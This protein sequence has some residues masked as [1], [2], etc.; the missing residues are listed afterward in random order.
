MWLNA[1]SFYLLVLS[2]LHVN[3][4][5]VISKQDLLRQIKKQ[6]SNNQTF[7]LFNFL[8][9]QRDTIV[10]DY[11]NQ[12]ITPTIA[13]QQLINI[14]DIRL[15]LLNQR[16]VKDIKPLAAMLSKIGTRQA[17]A[18]ALILMEELVTN[19]P[20]PLHFG[21]IGSL[22]E[23]MGNYEKAIQYYRNELVTRAFNSV[24]DENSIINQNNQNNQNN[25]KKKKNIL[26][27]QFIW[28]WLHKMFLL[29]WEHIGLEDLVVGDYYNKLRTNLLNYICEKKV[30]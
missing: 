20:H 6:S 17:S 25:L 8:E 4:I 18:K 21:E 26:C 14:I 9:I 11:L 22:H 19:L 3:T 12:Y 5:S 15:D 1:F 10:T 27:S 7:Q 30:V 24:N 2:V 29:Y 13:S 28:N 16:I 23:S